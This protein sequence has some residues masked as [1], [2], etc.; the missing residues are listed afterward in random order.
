MA[1][2]SAVEPMNEHDKLVKPPLK[3]NAK[4]EP[5]ELDDGSMELHRTPVEFVTAIPRETL[6]MA[7]WTAVS[8]SK[9]Q[10]LFLK[11]ALDAMPSSRT[12]H[13]LRRSL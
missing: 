3:E 4:A 10:G 6:C 1:S 11:S 12:V 8:P 13:L 7:S 9:Q 2:W 5:L